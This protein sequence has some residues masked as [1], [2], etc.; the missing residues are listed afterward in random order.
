MKTIKSLVLIFFLSPLGVVG[1]GDLA[2]RA[3]SQ[4]YQE[5]LQGGGGREKKRGKERE[6]LGRGY[7]VKFRGEGP[8]LTGLGRYK[9]VGGGGGGSMRGIPGA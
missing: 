3:Y 5:N 7:I 9:G 2:Y 8:S 1:G 6:P 4:H